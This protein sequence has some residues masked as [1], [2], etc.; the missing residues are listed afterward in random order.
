VVVLAVAHPWESA[1]S[2]LSS[3]VPRRFSLQPSCHLGPRGR[4]TLVVLPPVSRFILCRVTLLCLVL[5]WP[6]P[7]LSADPLRALAASSRRNSALL[8]AYF[9]P[10]SLSSSPRARTAHSDTHSD[11][12]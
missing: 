12:Y 4:P 5:L 6:V 3:Q 2:Y 9:G 7:P 1:S 8:A 11:Q 10:S